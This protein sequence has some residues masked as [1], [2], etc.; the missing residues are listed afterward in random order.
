MAIP[1]QAARPRGTALAC[2]L[3]T[4]A[5]VGLGLK[6]HVK[7]KGATAG[8]MCEVGKKHIRPEQ[9]R[10]SNAVRDTRLSKTKIEARTEV[11]KVIHFSRRGG[12]GGKVTFYS[13][14]FSA[15]PL[16]LNRVPGGNYE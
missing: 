13:E 11:R 12:R 4:A 1:R 3:G 6:G 15:R 9:W 7:A 2:A 14:P 8:P 10:R 5:A 16:L